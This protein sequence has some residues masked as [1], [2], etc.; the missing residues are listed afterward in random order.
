MKTSI[1][2][3]DDEQHVL[4]IFREAF[5]DDYDV[6]T[7]STVGEARRELADRA[8]DIVI[9]DQSMPEITGTEFLAEV[10][11]DYPSGYRIMLTGSMLVGEA[12]PE[13]SSG[14]VHLFVSKPWALEP[15]RCAL[16][17]ASL[18]A[19]LRRLSD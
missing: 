17:R 13:L 16:E 5:G 10:A 11:R 12:I 18:H 19:S 6:R 3:L 1:L 9:S 2:Y 7:A 4:S 8:A 14:I 15:M